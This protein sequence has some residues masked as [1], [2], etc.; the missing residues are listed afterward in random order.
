MISAWIIIR[1]CLAIPWAFT[2]LF[3]TCGHVCC[4]ISVAKRGVS[5]SVI[6]FVGGVSGALACLVLP[7]EGVWR[8][9]WLPPLIDFS[10]FLILA[11]MLSRRNAK[12][13]QA[14]KDNETGNA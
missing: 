8:W 9:F 6:P 11:S 2:C 10:G 12:L 4:M 14:L 13:Q 3:C 1:W 7:I 5:I